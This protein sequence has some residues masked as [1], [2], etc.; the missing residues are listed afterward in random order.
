VLGGA[1]FI[2]AQPEKRFA[3]NC[4]D[5]STQTEMNECAAK[6]AK[7]ADAALNATYRELIEKI[8][9]DKTATERVIAAEKA[10][11]SFR[12]AELAAEWP[13]AKGENPNVLYGS[14]HPLCYFNELEAM[15]WERVKR[16]KELM[17][18]AEGDVC[19]SGLA[20]VGSHKTSTACGANKSKRGALN[21]RHSVSIVSMGMT[22]VS[23]E[24][25]HR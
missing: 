7:R 20:I 9:G 4:G 3:V 5:F 11:I 12:D 13:V 19:S 2:Q 18:S 14:V 8:K 25:R 21:E 16:L 15:T 23:G 22:R 10:W 6:Q 24:T 1:C 17:Q